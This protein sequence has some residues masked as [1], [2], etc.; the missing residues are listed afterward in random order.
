MDNRINAII[1]AVAPLKKQLAE[2]GMYN[3]LSNEDSIRLF[4]EHHV[5]AVWDF[6]SL[7][8]W[9]QFNLV[10]KSLPWVPP[11]NGKIARF[12]NEIV[13]AEESDVDQN[14]EYLS[15]FEMYLN[16]M[17]EIGA[18]THQMDMF[19][20][21]IKSGK[22]VSNTCEELVIKKS[23]VRFM[24]FTFASIQSEKAHV[25]ASAF[26]FG[27]E[28]VIPEMF[29]NILEKNDL[30]NAS[31]L[32]YYLQRHIELDGDEHG[33]M[34]MELLR[35]LCGSDADKWKEAEL[36]AITALNLRIR[37]W[38]EVEKTLTDKRQYATQF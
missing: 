6:M 15:H 27:R 10:S 4:M 16:S 8:K 21:E 37:L 17:K 33:P 35:V 23:I 24:A 3:C 7:T 30:K 34:A 1:S 31:G 26:T 28:D 29:M 22:S 25:V 19:L 12:V 20:Q 38:D 13:L 2:H 32:K 9:L 36:A 18:D 5:F 14:G 11:V